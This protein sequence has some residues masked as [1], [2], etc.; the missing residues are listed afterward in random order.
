MHTAYT[1][2]IATEQRIYLAS[3][4]LALK[5][6]KHLYECFYLFSHQR[7]LLFIFILYSELLLPLLLNE[8]KT[9]WY[10]LNRLFS[11][12]YLLSPREQ[13]R[14]W[15]WWW[16]QQPEKQTQIV[17][18]KIYRHFHIRFFFFVVV[19]FLSLLNCYA[20]YASYINVL[21]HWPLPTSQSKLPESR[22][23]GMKNITM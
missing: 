9:V 14:R 3:Q 8:N 6:E 1:Q 12:L 17:R 20:V 19:S 18:T 11:I 22:L 21:M 23:T 7:R 10:S 13:R 5:K 16:W 2:H 15:W 4:L